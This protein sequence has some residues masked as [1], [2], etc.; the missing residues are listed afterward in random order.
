ML[1]A[2]ASIGKQ[3]VYSVRKEV[4]ESSVSEGLQTL[5]GNEKIG[6]AII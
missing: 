4:I 1:R 3:V 5:T 2:A 6:D